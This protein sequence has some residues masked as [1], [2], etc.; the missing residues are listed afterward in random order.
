MSA[1]GPDHRSLQRNSHG[2][3]TAVSGDTRVKLA[4]LSTATIIAER[5]LLPPLTQARA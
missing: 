3:Y 5:G 1:T 4:G 2:S